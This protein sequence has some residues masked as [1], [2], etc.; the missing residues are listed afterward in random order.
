MYSRHPSQIG[1]HRDVH[2]LAA[3][4]AVDRTRQLRN[5]FVGRLGVVVRDATIRDTAHHRLLG[6]RA[7]ASRLVAAAT[8][9]PNSPKGEV[10][11]CG[12]DARTIVMLDGSLRRLTGRRTR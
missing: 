7:P 11:R 10:G 3:D 6:A 5:E 9:S 12:I 1:G 4:A 2:R 8:F